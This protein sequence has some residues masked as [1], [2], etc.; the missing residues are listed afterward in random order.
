M[1]KNEQTLPTVRQAFDPLCTSKNFTNCPVIFFLF[2]MIGILNRIRKPKIF[3]KYI[4]LL[5]D[6]RCKQ[7]QCKLVKDSINFPDD[8]FAL[9]LI[10]IWNNKENEYKG[11]STYGEAFA[12][13]TQCR[14]PNQSS[15]RSMV[16]WRESGSCHPPP[17]KNYLA[18]CVVY[19]AARIKGF[20]IIGILSECICNNDHD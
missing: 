11:T 19:T 16:K 20:D 8:F 18:F 17:L 14:S 4:N 2:K 13:K 9:F 3:L 6:I 10:G 15:R 1:L 5:W 7:I 12:A